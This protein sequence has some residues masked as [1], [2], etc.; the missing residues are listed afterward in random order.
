MRRWIRQEHR[1]HAGAFATRDVV[2]E[3]YRACIT[4]TVND[5]LDAAIGPTLVLAAGRDALNPLRAQREL[6]RRIRRSAFHVFP[7]LG[8]LLPYEATRECAELI[9][10]WAPAA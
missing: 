6:T 1:R 8:H 5:Y 10:A 3:S 9:A 7:M 2:F 4:S